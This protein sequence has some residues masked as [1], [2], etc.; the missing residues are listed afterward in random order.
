MQFRMIACG[1]L[2]IHEAEGTLVQRQDL[3]RSTIDHI[4]V[5]ISVQFGRRDRG[6]LREER[7]E[8]VNILLQQQFDDIIILFKIQVKGCLCF[9][10]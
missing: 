8:L 2:Q 1:A 10:L 4:Q 9:C 7:G 3:F 5:Q 6:I